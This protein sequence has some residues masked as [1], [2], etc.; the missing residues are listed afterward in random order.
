MAKPLHHN[1]GYFESVCKVTTLCIP[2]VN[3]LEHHHYHHHHHHHCWA[4]T[5]KERGR[6]HNFIAYT[7]GPCCTCVSPLCKATQLKTSLLILCNILASIFQPVTTKSQGNSIKCCKWKWLVYI[8]PAT[9]ITHESSLRLNLYGEF[10]ICKPVHHYN[11][12]WINQP[13]AANS[14]VYY[15]SFKYI[16]TCFE[17]PHVHHQELQQLQ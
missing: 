11:F 16:P 7:F 14:Q 17:L 8:K 13:D 4:V 5:F 9:E 12:N 6:K 2:L 3:L 1:V 15:L 10:R